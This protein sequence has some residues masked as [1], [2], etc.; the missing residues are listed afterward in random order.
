[1]TTEN[2]PL[3]DMSDAPLATKKTHFKRKNLA[4]Q[5]VRFLSFT[6]TMMKILM[7]GGH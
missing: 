4:Y 3:L 6:L 5:A 2:L 7:K 1:M